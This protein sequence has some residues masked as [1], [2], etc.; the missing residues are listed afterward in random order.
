MRPTN[1]LLQQGRER[2][3]EV[4]NQYAKVMRY[5]TTN[6]VTMDHHQGHDLLEKKLLILYFF[7]KLLILEYIY[8]YLH[9]CDQ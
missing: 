3:Q 6:K 8:I 7:I 9:I 2:T 4:E 1:T 5:I